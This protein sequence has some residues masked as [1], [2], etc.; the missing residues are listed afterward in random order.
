M[1]VDTLDYKTAQ[2]P[3]E[4]YAYLRTCIGIGAIYNRKG[5]LL[6]TQP[7][8]WVNFSLQLTPILED[9]ERDVEDKSKLQIYVAGCLLDGKDVPEVLKGRATVLE[10]IAKLGFKECIRKIQWA[11]Y[12]THQTLSLILAENRGEI[13]ENESS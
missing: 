6:H 3:E 1:E 5:Y 7:A 12:N 13:E 4:L 10:S 2:A 11:K 8:G 9:L